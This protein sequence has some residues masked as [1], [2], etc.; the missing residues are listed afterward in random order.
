LVLG[1]NSPDS[2]RWGR[3]KTFKFI[4][5]Q[6]TSLKEF[7][8]GGDGKKNKLKLGASLTAFILPDR[9]PLTLIAK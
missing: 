7:F 2:T 9:N 5:N 6:G 8:I 4:P 1:E 3:A